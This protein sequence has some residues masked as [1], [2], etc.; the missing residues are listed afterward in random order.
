MRTIHWTHLLVIHSALEF[1]TKHDKNK[2]QNQQ[3]MQVWPE[4][5]ELT[6]LTSW[7]SAVHWNKQLNMVNTKHKI[8]KGGLLTQQLKIQLTHQL[9]IHSAS[10]Q[11]IKH[12][13]KQANKRT[14]HAVLALKNL[15]DWTHPL[16]INS[17]LKQ[18]T[19]HGKSNEKVNK[20]CQF[21]L[22]H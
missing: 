2:P 20:R 4:T 19:K 5:W 11:A 17:A 10:K 21:K 12:M 1:S 3:D 14:I 9:V 16:V 22:L 7:W 18:G 15:T 13:S 8:N 6:W